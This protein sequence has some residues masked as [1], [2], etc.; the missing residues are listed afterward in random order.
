MVLP[1]RSAAL[2]TRRR[3][4]FLTLDEIVA[5]AALILDR[6]GYDALN[7][8]AIGSELGVQAAAL[9]R[10][11]TSRA[12]LDDLLFDHLMADCAPQ[13]RGEDWR[14]D[15]RLVADAWRQRLVSRRDAT[16]IALGQV[17]IGPNVAPIM[18]AA[19]DALRRSGLNDR[20][21]VEAYNA[22][23]VFVLGFA[24]EEASYFQASSTGQVRVAPLRP[25][26]ADAY[27]T[28]SRLIEPLSAPPDFESRFAFGFEA[29]I[30]GI[31]RRLATDAE[32]K[33]RSEANSRSRAVPRTK[34]RKH[35]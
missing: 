32:S 14:E 19:L 27:P 31:E 5:A 9:Y 24:S 28:L 34:K 15:L 7:M 4:A 16:R 1:F 11:V 26:W 33:P 6:D 22:C 25:E 13:L 8:R 20:D 18:D 10:H 35:P 30:A 23:L 3:A 17:S 29:L 2:P 12:E 21:I